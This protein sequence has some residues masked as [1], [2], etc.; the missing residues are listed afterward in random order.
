MT[1]RVW[2]PD[3][4]EVR[5]TM[6]PQ[7]PKRNS[8]V[9]PNNNWASATEFTVS[10][11]SAG[12]AATQ[13]TIVITTKRLIVAIDRA[14]NAISYSDLQGHVVLAEDGG[15]GKSM[16]RA[17]IAGIATYNCETVFHSPVDEGLFGLGCHPLDSLAINYKGRNQ[18]LLI[19]YMTGA[20]PVLLST[21]GYSLHR[22]GMAGRK[23]IQNIVMFPRAVR[24]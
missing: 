13:G 17:S 23:I 6:L 3:V 18:D 7:L 5:Y 4:I 19:K 16:Q 15:A 1:I 24:P 8:L 20:I 22:S 2:Q 12:G 9:I 14:T 11:L 10:E 21:K